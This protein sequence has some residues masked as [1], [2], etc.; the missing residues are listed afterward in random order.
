M[1]GEQIAADLHCTLRRTLRRHARAPEAVQEILT[2]RR[3][4]GRG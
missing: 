1:T 2:G 3:G 4:K